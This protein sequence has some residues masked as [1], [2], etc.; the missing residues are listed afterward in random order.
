MSC[1]NDYFSIISQ[2]YRFSPCKFD[3]QNGRWEI[4]IFC[5]GSYR[6]LTGN[7][8]HCSSN[9]RVNR[10][11]I[12]ITHIWGAIIIASPSDLPALHRS[13]FEHLLW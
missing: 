7:D 11:I 6:M 2:F 5:V 8:I 12:Y 9:Y 10:S 13:T 4:Q 1:A 3:V